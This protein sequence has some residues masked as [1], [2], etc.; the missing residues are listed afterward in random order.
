MKR[1]KYSIS[2]RFLAALFA[3]LSA[4]AAVV[5]GF[6]VF[7]IQETGLYDAPLEQVISRNFKKLQEF[8]SVNIY[9]NKDTNP[10]CLKNTNLEYGIIKGEPAA[11][12]DLSDTSKYDYYN[13]STTPEKDSLVISL[14]ENHVEC[15]KMKPTFFESL[16]NQ[17]DYYIHDTDEELCQ[18]PLKNL[19]YNIENGVFYYNTSEYIFPIYHILLNSIYVKQKEDASKKQLAKKTVTGYTS[20]TLN[21]KNLQ[22]ESDSGLFEPL[23]TTEYRKWQRIATQSNCWFYPSDIL[24]F[25]DKNSPTIINTEEKDVWLTKNQTDY[26]K[27]RV[28][29][30][31]SALNSPDNTVSIISNIPEVLDFEKDDL[32]VQQKNALTFLYTIRIPCIVITICCF[33]CFLLL[34]AFCC[35]S[36]GCRID[37]SIVPVTRL[38]RLPVLLYLAGTGSCVTGL[39]FAMIWCMEGLIHTNTMFFLPFLFSLS[40]AALFMIA[41]AMNLSRRYKAGI[42]WKTTFSYLLLVGS[43]RLLVWTKNGI[44]YI[45][46]LFRENTSLLLKGILVLGAICLIETMLILFA[47]T[48]YDSGMVL[49]VIFKIVEFIV[50]L[51]VLLQMK[52]LQTGSRLLAEGNLEHKLDTSHMFWEFKKQGEYLNQIGD[53][54]TIALEERMKSEH[55]RTELITN[56]SHDI[57]TPLTSIINYIDL[58]QRENISP[59][60]SKEY[61]EVLERQSAR[62]KK[63]I[64]DLMDASKA[65]TGNM[66]VTIEECDITILLTQI[67]GEFEEKLSFNQ[68]E[69]I[70]Q[71]PDTS[72]PILADNRHLFRIFENLLNNICKYSQPG[73]RVYVNLETDETKAWIIFRNISKYPLTVSGEAL[74][75]RFARGDVSRSTEGNGLGLSIAQSLAEL[76]KGT[77]KIV[78]DGDLFKAILTFPRNM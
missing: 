43:R 41:T 6:T 36:T 38:H 13:F 42:L 65:S 47:I 49:W 55:F 22:Y 67:F 32:F 33:I 51:I 35:Y 48:T 15:N 71:S 76:M 31:A 21:P 12:L 7:L 72:V 28:N 54:M 27:Y 14:S 78:T 61:L 74:L 39:I 24:V 30:Y 11:N 2:L 20:F 5:G 34:L 73:T 10:G 57:K 23:D 75:E 16:F 56:V 50:V 3:V 63:L 69:L 45:W 64:E 25:S 46:K 77:L 68:L 66:S 59:E 17:Y 1:L 44:Q 40:L 52:Q 62:L 26:V 60:T 9:M 4:I 29:Y 18:P 53:G 8:Y 37:T 19:L 70:T 58:L